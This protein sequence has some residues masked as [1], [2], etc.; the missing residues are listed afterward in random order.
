MKIKKLNKYDV[1]IIVAIVAIV[2]FCAISVLFNVVSASDLPANYIGAAL[3]SFIGA[4]ITLVLLRGQT[5]IEEKKG[6]DIRILKKKTKVFQKYIKKVWKVW[7]DQKITIEEFQK[8]TSGY[9]QKLMMYLKGERLETIG[10]C[11]SKMGGY[12]GT[13]KPGELRKSVV[14][15][16][17]ELS[18]EIELGGKINEDIMNAHDEI[19][20]PLIFRQS[21]QE[22]F[23]EHFVSKYSALLEKAKWEKHVAYHAEHDELVIDF[24]DYPGCS[25]RSG[26][27]KALDDEKSKFLF[28]LV[29]PHGKKYTLFNEFRYTKGGNF[30]QWIKFSD[31]AGFQW[32]D[33]CKPAGDEKETIT[34]F[35]FRDESMEKI[36]KEGNY[37]DIAESL[38]KRAEYH[39][40]ETKIKGGR[41][42]SISE[43]MEEFGKDLKDEKK[44]VR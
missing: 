20:F 31:S 43:F 4:I 3:G 37:V 27:H 7:K 39:F 35:D 22:A 40:R 23:N 26:I 1:A 10:N 34:A 29:V 12:I 24:K 2:A 32:T 6:K 28:L 36:I 42:Y 11:L 8:L 18:A 5:E 38:A 33:L 9:Y 14:T 13:N 44:T 30:S 17:N 19:L 16:I 41:D 15:I 25:I 21:L